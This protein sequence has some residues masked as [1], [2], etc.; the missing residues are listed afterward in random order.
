MD[1]LHTFKIKIESWHSEHGCI[2]DQ[3]SF[4]NQDQDAKP[5]SG[6]S[7]VLQSPKW[8]LKGHTNSLQLQ[9]QDQ[10]IK[11]G[12]RVHQ[13]PVT[14]SKSRSR[15]QTPIRNLQHPKKAQIRTLMTRMIFTPTK[16]LQTGKIQNFA[17]SMTSDNFQI[18]I[19]MLN[20]S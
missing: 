13:R 20:P 19:K 10:E 14:I 12:T 15:C 18:K 11:L 4:P 5:Q 17:L 8:G 2:K 6:T 16:S 9:N 7:S 1:V 3:W